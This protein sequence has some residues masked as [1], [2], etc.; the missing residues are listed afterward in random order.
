MMP[1]YVITGGLGTGKTSVLAVLRHQFETIAEPARELIAEHR[2][3]TGEPGLDR[4]PEQF[5]QRLVSRSIEKYHSASESGVTIF[6]RGLPD[7]VAYARALGANPEPVF[8]VAAAYRY[9]APVFV[10]PP[11]REIYARDDMRRATFA[12]SEA[13]YSYAMAAYTRLGYETIQLPKTSVEERAAFV[14][15]HVSY[16][17]NELTFDREDV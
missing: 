10:A 1:R 5:L 7:C 13:F 4:R 12:E 3:A 17:H 16:G 8:E 11:W 2:A 14:S 9:A 15:D 6:D